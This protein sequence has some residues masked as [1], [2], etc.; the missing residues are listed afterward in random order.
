MLCSSY[1]FPVS[2]VL[3]GP[4]L[5]VT[6][7]YDGQKGSSV[8]GPMNQNHVKGNQNSAKESSQTNN[9]K[10][11]IFPVQDKCRRLHRPVGSSKGCSARVLEH[12]IICQLHPWVYV[13]GGKDA[14][15]DFP[16]SGIVPL[17]RLAIGRT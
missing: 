9:L 1:V 2:A 14:H 17:L 13:L 6:G 8:L 4:Q 10:S 5:S 16:C 3:G 11:T 12:V 15:S 7:S